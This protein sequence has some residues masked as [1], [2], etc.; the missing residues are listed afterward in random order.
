MADEAIRDRSL[1]LV[2]E[3]LDES[4]SLA[5]AEEILLEEGLTGSEL[6]DAIE[7]AN[8]ILRFLRDRIDLYYD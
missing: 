6:M 2:D 4:I 5:D 8:D 3:F 7:E 1:K